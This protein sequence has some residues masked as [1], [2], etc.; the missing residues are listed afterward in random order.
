MQQQPVVQVNIETPSHVA[1]VERES[2]YHYL[3]SL[4]FCPKGT[5]IFQNKS[6]FYPSGTSVVAS[7]KVHPTNEIVTKELSEIDHS[8]N[9]HEYGREYFG[10]DSF[11]DH[12]CD[13]STKTIWLSTDDYIVVALRDIEAGEQ[14]TCD[15][16]N[17]TKID[18]DG[19]KFNCKCG[20]TNCR[21]IIKV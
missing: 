3:I 12:S 7:F 6:Q 19:V 9:R 20:S 5:V 2:F 4:V 21:Q 16:E 1:I 10:F 18:F 14:I 17:F 13:P 11:S 15:Y 8:V